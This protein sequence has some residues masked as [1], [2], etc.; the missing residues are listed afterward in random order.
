M[1]RVNTMQDVGLK[2]R[3]HVPKTP[4]EGLDS[5]IFEACFFA[6]ALRELLGLCMACKGTSGNGC[7][8][9]CFH[10]A[11][12]AEIVLNEGIASLCCHRVSTGT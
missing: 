12:E 6:A 5:F 9:A 10:A 3:A 1:M 7:L 8:H 11:H 2:S 4:M